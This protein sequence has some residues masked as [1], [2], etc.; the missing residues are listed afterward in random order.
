MGTGV[1]IGRFQVP[2][3]TLGHR[4]LLTRAAERSDRLLV[5][6]GTAPT[7][8]TQR[9]P[10]SYAVR[11]TMVVQWHSERMQDPTSHPF[12]LTVLPL[13][14]RPTDAGWVRAIDEIISSGG[15]HDVTLYGGR[16][17][18]KACYVKHGGRWQWVEFPQI[19]ATS[20]TSVRAEVRAQHS[21]EFRAGVIFAAH[22]KFPT[23]YPTVDIVIYR[24]GEV[25]LAR[26]STEE[27][28]RFVGGFVEPTDHSLEDAAVR[29]AREETGLEIGVPVYVGSSYINDWRYQG[30]PEAVISSV[31]VAQYI[32][33]HPVAHD[34]VAE[35]AWVLRDEVAGRLVSEHTGLWA[36]AKHM[37]GDLDTIKTLKE[38]LKGR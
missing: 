9:N 2:E 31:F 29:E 1:V 25:L 21:P 32:F 17:S 20:G 11:E 22:Q 13:P 34:D 7:R 15:E 26:K 27:R 3:L 16:D 18:A 12:D 35:L 8:N 23:V 19:D 37:L 30:G 6:I 5:L 10:L 33:G 4:A 36:L 38:T 24:P 28:W 14:D